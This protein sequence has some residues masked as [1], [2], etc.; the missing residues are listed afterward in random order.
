MRFLNPLFFFGLF[1]LAV[2]VIIHLFNFRRYKTSYFSNVKLLQTILLKTK[3]ES[4]LQHLIVLLLRLLGI[5]ALVFAFAQPYIPLKNN[6][7]EGGKVIA[8]FVDNSYSMESFSQ[9]GSLLQDA[10]DAAKNVVNAF[11]YSDDFILITNDFSAKESRIL[12]KDEMLNLLDELTI[13]VNSRSLDEILAF[14]K[15]IASYSTKN[16]VF[17]YYISDFQ[18]SQ[19]DLEHFKAD[20]NQ[21]AFLLPLSQK[22]VN[23]IGIDSCWFSSP[24]FI[25][26]QQITLTVRVRNYGE[27]N[28]EKLPLRLFV[29]GN[30]KSIAAIDL[31]AF[32]FADYAL[33]YNITDPGIQKA[34]LQI[35]DTPITFDDQLFFVYHVTE[36][37]SIIQISSKNTNNRYIQALYGKDSTFTF[38]SMYDDQVDYAAFDAANLIILDQLKSISSGLA[39]ELS[40]YV[41]KGGSILVFPHEELEKQGW[42]S[43]LSDLGTGSYEN[44]IQQQMSGGKVNEESIYYKRSMNKTNERLDMP[45]ITQHFEISKQSLNPAEILFTMENDDPLLAAYQVEGGRVFLSAV[46]MNDKFGAAHK[47]ALYIVPLHNMGIMQQIQSKLYLTIGTDE[48]FVVNKKGSHSEDLFKIKAEQNDFEFIPEQRITSAGTLLFMHTQITTPGFYNTMKGDEQI[49]TMAFNLS[50]K[51]SDLTY[52][53]DKELDAI[54]DSDV[55]SFQILNGTAKNLTDQI[56]ANLTGKTLWRYFLCLVL[57]CFLTEIALLRF[58]GRAKAV[59]V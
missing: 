57:L 18:K 25:L 54:A 46:A 10:V 5:T 2:P 15:N 1:A 6:K 30:Q 42:N 49:N 17:S 13:S 27:N 41:K 32:S 24:V 8:V 45:L 44:L 59:S 58:W 40:N 47:H 9:S 48:V 50:R 26:G 14:Q 51:E 36:T 16:H 38:T 39:T 23:N 29:N 53:T 28:I 12:N 34:E 31:K 20:S 56:A 19:F 35:D 52:Y 22:Q 3:K 37:S 4:Q 33:H 21:R 43:F 11:D 55:A 7:I